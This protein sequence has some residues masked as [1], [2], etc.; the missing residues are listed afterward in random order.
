MDVR[1]VLAAAVFGG[2]GVV[3][4]AFGAHALRMRL[5]PDLLAVFETGVRYQMYHALALL[6]VALLVVKLPGTSMPATAGWLF[7][8]GILLFSGSL[9]VLTLTGLRWMGAI[10][11]F[12]GVAFVAGWALLALAALRAWRVAPMVP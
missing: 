9:Y 11:P 5:T 3:L 12:G 1:F 2:L 7:I 4:G 6:G 8:A 10:T